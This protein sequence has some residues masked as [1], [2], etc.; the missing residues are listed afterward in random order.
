MDNNF[1][2]VD[3][4]IFVLVISRFGN[5]QFTST[6]LVKPI[7][8]HV[9]QKYSEYNSNSN[10]LEN[11]VTE[12]SKLIL[13]KNKENI[14]MTPDYENSFNITPKFLINLFL[15]KVAE[16]TSFESQLKSII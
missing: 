14:K 9:S 6:T 11:F 12:Y 15:E 5:K 3:L 13:N 10:N 8:F 2:F 1:I 16:Q 7:T 4:F